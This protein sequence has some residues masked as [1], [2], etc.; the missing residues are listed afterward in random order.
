MPLPLTARAE[1]PACANMTRH[2]QNRHWQHGKSLM[3][4]FAAS[5][6]VEMRPLKLLAQTFILL[7]T[8]TSLHV[9]III[10]CWSKIANRRIFLRT[11]CD[12]SRYCYSLRKLSVVISH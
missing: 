3:R 4:L 8:L 9:A 10:A 11:V 6:D 7:F 1:R 5:S 12:N 2:S